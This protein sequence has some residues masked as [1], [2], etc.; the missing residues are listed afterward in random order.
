MK[1]PYSYLICKGVLPFPSQAVGSSTAAVS[2]AGP[3]A[4]EGAAAE[5]V[6]TLQQQQQQWWC[7]LRVAT[8]W[9]IGGHGYC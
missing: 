6:G 5:Q 2:S 8:S 4:D 9:S 3:L 1:R 7:L